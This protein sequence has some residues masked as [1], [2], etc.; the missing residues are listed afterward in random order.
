MPLVS[1]EIGKDT[2]DGVGLN[3][4]S[5]TCTP[6]RRRVGGTIVVARNSIREI[7]VGTEKTIELPSTPLGVAMKI[8]IN[9]NH[10]EPIEGYYKIPNVESISF[11]KLVEIDPETLEA[12]EPEPEWWAVANAT[13]NSGKVVGDRLILARTDG[14]EVDAGNV[15]GLPGK[16]GEDGKDGARGL[17]G[18][19]G[20]DGVAGQDGL[21]GVGVVNTEIDA[22]GDLL[23][24]LSNDQVVNAGRA[25]G[26]DGVD[27]EV[28]IDYAKSNFIGRSELFVMVD[29]YGAVGDGTTDDTAPFQAALDFA[30]SQERPVTVLLSSKSYGIGEIFVPSNVSLVGVTGSNLHRLSGNTMINLNGSSEPEIEISDEIT[31]E[32]KTI[33]TKVEHN[34]SPGDIIYLM[35]Q[36]DSLSDDAELGWRLGYATPN[37]GACYYAEFMTVD[38]VISTTSFTVTSA[39]IFPSYLPNDLSELSPTSRPSSTVMKINFNSGVKIANIEFTGA[40]A[41]CVKSDWAKDVTLENLTFRS[42][43]DRPA[44]NISRSLTVSV[45]NCKVFYPKSKSSAL[46]LRNAFKVISSTGVDIDNCYVEN[47]SQCFD[48]TYTPFFGPS[49]FSVV[50]NSRT[51]WA[52]DN[53]ATSHGGSYSVDFISNRFDHNLKNGL[54]VRSRESKI[55]NNS[56]THAYDGS[57]TYG[58]RLYE[59]SAVDCII[60]GNTVSGFGAGVDV[61]DAPDMGEKFGRIGAI[62]TGN[63]VV[64]CHTG[65][66]VVRSSSNP[67]RGVSDLMISNN[68]VSKPKLGG[69]GVVLGHHVYSASITDNVFNGGGLGST[70]VKL[71]FNCDKT[72]VNNNDVSG[73]ISRGID[74]RGFDSPELTS[75]TVYVW[76]NVFDTSF[77]VNSRYVAT[78]GG[79]WRGYAF[80]ADSSSFTTRVAINGSRSDGTALT[81]LLSRL[82]SMGIITNST[83]A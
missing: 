41:Q 17:P 67:Y 39:T 48:F 15:R 25:R 23:V 26:I 56:L 36:R 37:S 30:G 59:G 13:V 53:S 70:A 63:T 27:G 61:V 35:S 55:E 76:G 60:S 75:S 83:V 18:R 65:F 69:F 47:G 7:F 11:T 10:A 79:T 80:H 33:S 19:D 16:D 24:T 74:H 78:G 68:K 2:L 8:V 73:W 12:G 77:L 6:T 38:T 40:P 21:D 32:S 44:Y 28:T 22:S 43:N 1:F 5:I 49:M 72:R 81:E 3:S 52:Q 50:R 54:S 62:V 34:F 45:S 29:D 14:V 51:L 64:N 66:H 20:Y 9:S 4:G 82:N 42:T 31:A 57:T 71:E 46:Y 58:I